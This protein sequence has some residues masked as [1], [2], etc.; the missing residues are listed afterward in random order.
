MTIRIKG[1][2]QF[3]AGTAMYSVM[4]LLLIGV[5]A[6]VIVSFGRFVQYAHNELLSV[7]ALLI[8]VMVI[9]PFKDRVQGY[10]E[11]RLLGDTDI[12]K[13]PRQALVNT[14]LPQI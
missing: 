1:V 6:V 10:L 7:Y 3:V 14:A 9:L 13:I 8:V 11:Q 4:S 12:Y 5:Y 2:E